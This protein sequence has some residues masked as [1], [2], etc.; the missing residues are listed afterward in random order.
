MFADLRDLESVLKVN[1]NRPTDWRSG[2]EFY[3]PAEDGLKPGTINISPAW[4]EQGHEV[5]SHSDLRIYLII[6]PDG[7][8]FTE[9]LS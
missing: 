5:H 2:P 4:F 3:R 1:W 8:T 9:D 6:D 7:R